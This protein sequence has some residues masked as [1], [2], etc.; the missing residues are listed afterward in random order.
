VKAAR[1]FDMR[2][3]QSPVLQS[4]G[5]ENTVAS[6]RRN[7]VNIL[8]VSHTAP[9]QHWNVRR[10]AE[11]RANCAQ[12]WPTWRADSCDIDNDYR[13]H[14]CGY[15]IS[16]GLGSRQCRATTDGYLDGL[17]V[18]EVEA[19]DHLPPAERR[20]HVL[21]RFERL[22]RLEADDDG[23]RTKAEDMSCFLDPGHSSID[24]QRY[25]QLRKSGNNAVVT[26]ASENSIEIRDVEV[27]DSSIL[28]VVTRQRR[29]I[30]RFDTTASD[31]IYRPIT[32]SP[33]RDGSHCPSAQQVDDADDF[34]RTVSTCEVSCPT[35][36]PL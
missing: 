9:S 23:R 6:G 16:S 17:S 36:T 11:S 25:W 10:D 34:H 7:C 14:A 35:S 4:R 2:R 22:Q 1:F 27:R 18:A 15:A 26:A 30:S 19:K 28:H 31:R 24:P 3:C 21:E 32:I 20:A 29:C 8:Q 5:D 12:V 13:S 33:T